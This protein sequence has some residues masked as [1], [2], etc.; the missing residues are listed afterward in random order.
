M[1]TN[2]VLD[3][4]IDQ[5]VDVAQGAV[6]AI[7]DSISDLLPSQLLP[8]QLLPSRKTSHNRGRAVAVF[9]TLA[10]I[11]AGLMVVMAKRR[12]G[13]PLHRDGSAYEETAERAMQGRAPVDRAMASADRV[14]GEPS[15]LS[16]TGAA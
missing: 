13:G 2:R 8:S 1:T 14:N 4:A 10:V 16:K 15:A 11:A 5:A 3:T 9:S 7:G 6:H 12:R